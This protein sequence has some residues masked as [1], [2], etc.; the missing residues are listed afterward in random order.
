[1]GGPSIPDPPKPPAPAPQPIDPAI[2]EARR[3]MRSKAKKGGYKGTIL[4]S[5]S[6]LSSKPTLGLPSVLG[7]HGIWGQ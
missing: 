6:G 1:M 4:T 7:Q 2:L 3:R 5:P